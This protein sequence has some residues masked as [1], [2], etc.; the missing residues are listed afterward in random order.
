MHIVLG[1]TGNVGS[2]TARVL[3]RRGERVTVVTRDA[4]HATGLAGAGAQV[5]VA[6]IRNVSA[7]R[8]VFRSGDRAFLLNPPAAP[9]SDTDAEEREN[10]SAIL[11]AL[12]GSGL[13][14]VVLQSTYGAHEG[15][16]CGD[17]TVLYEFEQRLQAQSIPTAINRGAYYMTNW[18]GFAEAVRGGGMLPSFLPTHLAVPMIGSHDLGEAAARRLMEPVKATGIFHVEGPDRYTPK[19]VADAFAKVLERE[20]NVT[21]IPRDAWVETFL[22]FGFSDEAA[23]SYACMTGAIVDGKIESPAEFEKGSTSLQDFIR[24]I[25]ENASGNR[26]V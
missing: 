23:L 9:F 18:S 2:A 14:K 24:D 15:E 22:Q 7:L 19:D 26:S 11:E 1:G 20:V 17:L 25:L 8:D 6:D 3:L 12:V 13:S 4:D 10:A 16:R 5:A 21:E